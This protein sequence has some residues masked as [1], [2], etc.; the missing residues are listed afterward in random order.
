MTKTQKAAMAKSEKKT[1]EIV[2]S[3]DHCSYNV[4]TPRQSCCSTK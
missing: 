4:N 1:K 2:M 3:F